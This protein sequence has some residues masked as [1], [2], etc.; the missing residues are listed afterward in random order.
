MECRVVV[1]H[2]CE[3][4]LR[5]AFDA[6]KDR[7]EAAWGVGGAVTS[8]EDEVE[9]VGLGAEGLEGFGCTEGVIF[10]DFDVFSEMRIS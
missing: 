9:G 8:D 6:A 7:S 10:G 1:A 2:L 3:L 5:L 4:D